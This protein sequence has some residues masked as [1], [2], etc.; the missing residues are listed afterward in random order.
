MADLAKLRALD[1]HAREIAAGVVREWA[2]E[3]DALVTNDADEEAVVRA[4]LDA[5]GDMTV[6]LLP[7]IKAER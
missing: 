4:L 5:V 3:I 1:G 7:Q 2:N 6:A